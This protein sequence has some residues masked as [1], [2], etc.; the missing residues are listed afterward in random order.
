MRKLEL[1]RVRFS[2]R[3]FFIG[4]MWVNSE[5]SFGKHVEVLRWLILFTVFGC[6]DGFLSIYCNKL[7]RKNN[8]LNLNLW[9][10]TKINS[11]L[12]SLSKAKQNKTHV[13]KQHAWKH[14]KKTNK[15]KGIVWIIYSN[16]KYIR[17]A[18]KPMTPVRIR[19]KIDT[20]FFKWET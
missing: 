10:F 19:N 13:S 16:F 2:W 7:W 20:S 1:I 6:Q 12:I 11:R 5:G 3:S 9:K 15:N 17:T 14:E 4:K 18:H 8:F